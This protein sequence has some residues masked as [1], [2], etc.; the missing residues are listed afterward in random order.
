MQDDP[1]SLLSETDERRKKEK[2]EFEDIWRLIGGFGRY[3]FALVAFVSY[4]SIAVNLQQFVQIYYG[5]PPNFHCIS[6]QTNMTSQC[7]INKCG[8]SN[9]TYAFDNSSFTSAVSEV[10]QL[11]NIF[12]DLLM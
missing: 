6:S 10:G 4:I 8:C 3:P 2:A 1:K 9:C 12:V 11:P 5:T 7:G